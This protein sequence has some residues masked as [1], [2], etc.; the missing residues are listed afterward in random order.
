VL[1]KLLG[2][3]FSALFPFFFGEASGWCVLGRLNGAPVCPNGDSGCPNDTVDSFERQLLVRT[4]VFLR[5]LHGT[6]SGRHLRS[7]RMVNPVGLNRILPVPQPFYSPFFF[8]R[9]CRPVHFLCVF[10]A[11]L[12]RKHVIFAVYLHP[13][14][15]FILFY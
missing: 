11:Q 15:I 12:S 13:R 10:Y 1:W 4:S 3:Y 7:V 6:M 14:Y 8:V 2:K 9:F 5:S